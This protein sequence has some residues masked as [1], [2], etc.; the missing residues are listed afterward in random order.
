M[1]SSDLIEIPS[2][3][4]RERLRFA[5]L[6]DGPLL[7]RGR[8]VGMETAPVRPWPHQNIVAKHVLSTYPFSYLLCDEVG[9]G[10]TIEA[11][12]II[13]SLVLSGLAP[14]VLIAAPASLTR[15]WMREM[16]DKFLLPFALMHGG[17]WPR[18]E[19]IF[20]EQDVQNTFSLFE[21][22]LGIVSTGLLVRPERLKKL[23]ETPPFDLV[24]VDEA[25]YAR[26]KNP[27][28]GLQ[29]EP[30][31]GHLYKHISGI[32]RGKTECL[33]LA[34]ATP[35]QLDVVEVFDLMGLTNRVSAF[36]YEP[37]LSN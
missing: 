19:R 22:R 13:R 5:L 21:S 6:K 25:H 26:R 27:T 35:V 32:L 4:S 31:Y 30:K 34:T 23:Q 12:L 16:A 29:A 20:P 18:K 28:K 15:Q 33:L 2:P 9:L 7:P 11:G 37:G 24:L 10:K 8:F 1:C 14:R 36:Q 3:S 17:Q